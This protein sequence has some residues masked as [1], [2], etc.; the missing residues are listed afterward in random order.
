MPLVRQN[1]G[2]IKK[3]G[4]LGRAD[5]AFNVCCCGG[6]PTCPDLCGYYIEASAGAATYYPL[7]EGS[8]ER[9][10]SNDT[11][12]A[13]GAYLYYPRPGRPQFVVVTET[14]GTPGL[15]SACGLGTSDVEYTG[16]SR[17]TNILMTAVITARL[18]VGDG[19]EDE[20]RAQASLGLR[21]S[22]GVWTATVNWQVERFIGGSL[23]QCS[24]RKIFPIRTGCQEDTTCED[25]PGEGA[26]IHSKV[27]T[28]N[29]D[30]VTVSGIGTIPFDEDDREGDCSGNACLSAWRSLW[31]AR[32]Q[33]YRV[34]CKC[35][36]PCDEENPCPEGCACVDGE[37]VG[38]TGCC[39]INGQGST[40]YTQASCEDCTTTNV[41][42]EYFY[43]EDPEAS[44]PEGWASDGWGGCSRTTNPASCESCSG[45]CQ[46]QQSG[47]C[48]EWLGGGTCDM[49]Q[50]CD[51]EDPL[52]CVA[53]DDPSI[54]VTLAAAPALEASGGTWSLFGH[55]GGNTGPVFGYGF[56]SPWRLTFERDAG[57]YAPVA[58]NTL[59]APQNGS[60][61]L[62][63]RCGRWRVSSNGTGVLTTRNVNFANSFNLI[64]TTMNFTADSER[65]E[66]GTCGPED[67]MTLTGTLFWTASYAQG[68]TPASGSKQ[69]TVTVSGGAC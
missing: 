10:T 2:L 50:D 63:Q 16:T 29:G 62:E 6:C 58:F 34:P 57:G 42:D 3:S 68:G 61:G 65:L 39:C 1:G 60:Y 46:Q 24:A 5:N 54:T 59:W 53:L 11:F 15:P 13:E 25:P 4:A 47:V 55:Q 9:V 64:I 27:F 41:C 28:V 8:D 17:T 45:Y 49:V 32:F 36:G 14:E 51:A 52:V 33:V 22:N 19:V 7:K 44:C 18:A 20:P 35:S 66:S 12:C 38:G 23:V 48:G 21:C 40:G 31:Q 37:C 56:T 67:G 69:I 26:N 30:G 43:L